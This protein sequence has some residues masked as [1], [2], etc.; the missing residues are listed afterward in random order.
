M[1]GPLITTTEQAGLRPLGLHGQPVAE[2]YGQIAR[3]LAR[4]FSPKHAA[5]FAEPNFQV[6]PGM[7]EWYAELKRLVD[8]ITRKATELVASKEP[9]EQLLGQL[10]QLALKVPSN[11]YVYA[12][13]D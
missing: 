9:S 6:R 13:G 2:A 7:V 10:L 5:L 12:V 3:Y 11:D 4:A 1:A 8:A